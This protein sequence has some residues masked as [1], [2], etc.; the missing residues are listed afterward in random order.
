MNG[1][2]LSKRLAMVAS[3]V[4]KGARVA[5]IGSAHAYLPVLLIKSGKISYAVA[6][7][8]AKGPFE[9]AQQEVAKHSLDEQI[10]VRLANGLAAIS[11]ADQI[12]TLTIAGMGGQLMTD[13]L[14][15]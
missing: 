9:S 7:E 14:S 5:D 1:E 4:P 6:G 15:K 2:K 13:I 3:F 12:D 10:S 11:A 8:V